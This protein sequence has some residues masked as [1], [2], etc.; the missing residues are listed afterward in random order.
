VYSTFV[1]NSQL[2]SIS[3]GLPL[4]FFPGSRPSNTVLT[5]EPWR[6]TCPN[7]LFCLLLS[8]SMSFLLVS[9]VLVLHRSFCVPS[10]IFLT[11]DAKST[12]KM[13]QSFLCH[14]FAGSMSHFR[15]V[16]YSIRMLWLCVFQLEDEGSTH[17]IFLVESFLCQCNATSY[18][19][20][21]SAVFCRRT[22]KVAKLFE[23]LQLF[24]TIDHHSQLP[25]PPFW[26]SHNVGL[27][28]VYPHA[29]FL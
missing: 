18:F 11:C 24:F 5:K 8:V 21:T 16:L 9:T 2:S 28:H 27:V 12:F 15:T 17:E 26:H 14:S 1:S 23:W 19:T 4:S 25:A 3:F 10:K 29:V 22:S 6:S 20:F 13:P 7:Q